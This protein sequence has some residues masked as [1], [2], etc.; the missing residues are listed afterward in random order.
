MDSMAIIAA[1][2][3][4]K[5]KA[6]NRTF[7][8]GILENT[9]GIVLNNKPAPESGFSPKVN[10]TGNIAIPTSKDTKVSEIATL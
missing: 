2:D 8:N 9:K 7:P 1:K 6:V 10:T 5:K 4:N 3:V